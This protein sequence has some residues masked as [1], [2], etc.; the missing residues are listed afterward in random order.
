MIF[1]HRVKRNGVYYES[2]QDVPTDDKKKESLGSDQAPE[3]YLTSGST[4]L[5]DEAA[6]PKRGRPKKSE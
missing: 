3:E 4:F 5:E 1:N 2:G 6:T